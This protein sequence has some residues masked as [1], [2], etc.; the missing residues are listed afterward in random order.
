MRTCFFSKDLLVADEIAR[1]AI[2]SNPIATN[3]T[4]FG[5]GLEK[6][7]TS[8]VRTCVAHERIRI[9]SQ[10]TPKIIIVDGVANARRNGFGKPSGDRPR[11]IRSWFAK[12][13]DIDFRHRGFDAL[14]EILPGVIREKDLVIRERKTLD[15]FDRVAQKIEVRARTDGKQDERGATRLRC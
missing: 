3:L 4:D 11:G 15:G 5:I 6:G 12:K 7:N 2:A 13:Q 8:S 1:L 14:T 9:H 10:Q